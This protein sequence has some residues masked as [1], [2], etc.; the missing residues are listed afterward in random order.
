[1]LVAAVAVLGDA[2]GDAAACL[3]GAAAWIGV[4]TVGNLLSRRVRAQRSRNECY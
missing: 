1:V 4:L 3:L 2:V